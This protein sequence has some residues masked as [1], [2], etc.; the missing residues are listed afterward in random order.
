MDPREP[1]DYK[2]KTLFDENQ[3]PP[4][5][6]QQSAQQ[7][8]SSTIVYGVTPVA[9]VQSATAVTKTSS[10]KRLF[11]ALGV[12]FIIVVL[13]IV[14]TLVAVSGSNKKN[15]T[16]TKKATTTPVILQPATNIELEQINSSITQD[17]SGLDDEKDYPSGSLD[18]KSIGL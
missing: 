7:T 8:P 14:V 6:Q 1:H 2:P 10:K 5:Q 9:E 16:T 15:K 13:I 12:G 3:V 11:I 17:M 4:I 18:K